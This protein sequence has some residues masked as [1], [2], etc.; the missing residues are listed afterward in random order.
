MSAYEDNLRIELDKL[1]KENEEL[2]SLLSSKICNSVCRSTD[3]DKAKS[4]LY[5]AK[6]LLRD[7]VCP[8]NLVQIEWISRRAALNLEV[9]R[10]K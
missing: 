7:S 10:L 5:A 4:L 1:Q 3:Y 2:K 6:A 8:T 9:D